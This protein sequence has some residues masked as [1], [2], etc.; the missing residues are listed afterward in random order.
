MRPK[1]QGFILNF[2]VDPEMIEP[3]SLVTDAFHC[4]PDEKAQV[5]AVRQVS[6]EYFRDAVTCLV[7]GREGTWKA[8]LDP[9][10]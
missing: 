5:E 10:V 6:P 2:W 8:A 3:A 7:S 9:L 1:T 4:S